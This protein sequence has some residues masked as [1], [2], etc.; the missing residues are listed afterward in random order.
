MAEVD[1]YP[2]TEEGWDQLRAYFDEIG[3][4]SLEELIKKGTVPADVAGQ[5]IAHF[6]DM[7]IEQLRK[8]AD[9]LRTE[10]A[11]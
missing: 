11:G 6:N 4:H 8:R 5:R 9:E 2:T 1:Q 3:Q 7:L 10:Q